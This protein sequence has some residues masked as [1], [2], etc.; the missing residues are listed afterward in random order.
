MFCVLGYSHVIGHVIA[1]HSKEFLLKGL[2]LL[3]VAHCRSVCMRLSLLLPCVFLSD[4][5]GS[6]LKI[7]L[8][9]ISSNCS[10]IN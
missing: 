6:I 4:G 5:S 7:L 9:A 10:I 1:S 3:H 8:I 2:V